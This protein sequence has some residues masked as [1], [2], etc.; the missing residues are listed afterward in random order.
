MEWTGT[1]D[2]YKWAASSLIL[3]TSTQLPEGQTKVDGFYCPNVWCEPWCARAVVL[4]FSCSMNYTKLLCAYEN[5][6]QRSI[7]CRN[8]DPTVTLP[9]NI[10]TYPSTVD[11]TL[12][13][14]STSPATLP[15]IAS[16][17]QNYPDSQFNLIRVPGCG[18][19][20]TAAQQLCASYG[21]QLAELTSADDYEKLMSLYRSTSP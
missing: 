9:S 19:S 13:R 6:R 10:Y 5:E 1:S 3:N 15:P 14:P 7:L 18:Y 8:D 20:F 16:V 2:I 12:I 21:N 17:T 4:Q 11:G